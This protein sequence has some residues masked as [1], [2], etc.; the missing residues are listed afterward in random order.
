MRSI[1]SK[2]KKGALFTSDRLIVTIP[3]AD[4]RLSGPVFVNWIVRLYTLIVKK[5]RGPATLMRPVAEAIE[6]ALLALPPRILYSKV[7]P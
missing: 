7:Y 4:N 5:F 2:G 6:K 3:E 1:V